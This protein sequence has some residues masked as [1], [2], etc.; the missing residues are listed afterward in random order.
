MFVVVLHY[1]D[2]HLVQKKSWFLNLSISNLWLQ[3]IPRQL[4]KPKISTAVSDSSTE[5]AQADALKSSLSSPKKRV[6]SQ[7]ALMSMQPL[8]KQV[9]QK[10]SSPTKRAQSLTAHEQMKTMPCK[11]SAVATFGSSHTLSAVNNING[12][13]ISHS[14][15]HLRFYICVSIITLLYFSVAWNSFLWFYISGTCCL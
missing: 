10:K 15:N 12:G 7:K 11:Q 13:K 2:R 8:S 4:F 6:L 1:F 14:I 3:A 9:S 5:S